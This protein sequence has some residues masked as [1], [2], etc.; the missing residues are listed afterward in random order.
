MTKQQIQKM[1]ELVKRYGRLKHKSSKALH[2]ENGYKAGYQAAMS[3]V[4]GLI[5]ALEDCECDCEIS[6][7][8]NDISRD[9]ICH[10]C[11]SL[12]NWKDKYDI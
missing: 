5:E 1:E 9:V 3:E 11:Y 10:R 2:Y 4:D 12:K 7:P 6:L 8:V